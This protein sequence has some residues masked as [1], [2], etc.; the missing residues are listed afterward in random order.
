MI[1]KA[2]RILDKSAAGVGVG[3]V[4]GSHGGG[5]VARTSNENDELNRLLA[6]V[7]L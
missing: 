1:T 5:I 3:S 7:S 6:A 4:S 2:L